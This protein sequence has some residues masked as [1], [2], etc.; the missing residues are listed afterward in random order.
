VLFLAPFEVPYFI[1]ETGKPHTISEEV[2]LPAAEAITPSVLEATE[3]CNSVLL[4]IKHRADNFAASKMQ[5]KQ[6]FLHK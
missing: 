5:H 6:I 1:A 3:D 2:T 4:S